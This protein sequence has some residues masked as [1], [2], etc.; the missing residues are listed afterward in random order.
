MWRGS[1]VP[2]FGAREALDG[3]VVA[4]DC[5]HLVVVQP[6][7]RRD[8]QP[9]RL[10][11]QVQGVVPLGVMLVPTGTEQQNVAGAHL[12][13]LS[14]RRRVQI[15]RGDLPTPIQPVD[16]LQPGDVQQHARG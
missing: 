8:P 5:G 3:E 10:E 14:S 12:H 2:L 7:G 16:P 4:A 1:D 9:G 6:F 11:P 15:V 13:A